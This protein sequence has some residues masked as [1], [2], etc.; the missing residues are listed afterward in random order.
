M[1]SETFE[2]IAKELDITPAA[3]SKTLSD[4]DSRIQKLLENAARMNKIQLDLISPEFGFA[5]GNSFVFKV[6]TYIT[7]SPMNGVQVWYE[8][9]GECAGCEE[10]GTCRQGIH[11][12][13]KERGIVILNK[14]MRPTDLVELLFK[15]LEGMVQ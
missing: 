12:E 10:F 2:D 6:K 11:L 7:Y 1:A 15:K 8:H 3:V 4:A 5:R 13:F 9:E 14:Q